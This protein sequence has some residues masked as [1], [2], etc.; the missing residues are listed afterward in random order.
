MKAL[1]NRSISSI[2]KSIITIIWYLEFL[3]LLTPPL[4]FLDD[5]GITYKWPVTLSTVNTVPQVSATK[6]GIINFKIH[7]RYQVKETTVKRVLSFEDSSTGRRLI[8]TLHNLV[9]IVVIMYIT[10]L[11]KKIF[12]G[13]VK[14][15]PFDANNA[16]R[17]RL[18]GFAVLFWAGYELAESFL[19]R[20]Y[21]VST[22]KMEGAA[23][24]NYNN[25]F[26]VKTFVFGLLLL[27]IAEA[28]K[29]G[30]EYQADSESI[31]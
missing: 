25:S 23:F 9:T 11:L 24:D 12:S 31:L 16:G 1:G 7:D 5:D 19:Y 29:R 13:F 6:P 28:F 8:Q 10:W 18:I 2:L 4:V 30:T 17:I 21:T 15:K 27:I 26:D 14:D 3:L 22:I 20:I